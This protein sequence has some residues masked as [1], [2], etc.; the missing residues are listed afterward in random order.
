MYDVFYFL[1]EYIMLF[2]CRDMFVESSVMYLFD[3]GWILCWVVM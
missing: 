1:M 2:C 3:R